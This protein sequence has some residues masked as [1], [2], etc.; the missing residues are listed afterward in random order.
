MKIKSKQYIKLWWNFSVDVSVQDHLFCVL[1]VKL[2]VTESFA[3]HI[4][5][6]LVERVLQ[7]SW[8]QN[9]NLIRVSL[10]P[11]PHS[12]CICKHNPFRHTHVE[13]LKK[14]TFFYTSILACKVAELHFLQ[15]GYL[16]NL[17]K[18]KLK[19]FPMT[20]ELKTSSLDAHLSERRK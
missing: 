1:I 11:Y 15:C 20:L 10:S 13:C 9:H 7:A 4:Y 6:N 8:C 17:C 3:V 14:K 19:L 5:N 2:S 16:F 18:W 12:A